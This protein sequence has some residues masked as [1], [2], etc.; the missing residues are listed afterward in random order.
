MTPHAITRL[1]LV[2][3]FGFVAG[4]P[5]T[6]GPACA[7]TRYVTDMLILTVREGPGHEYKVMTTLRSNMAVEVLEEQEKYLKVRTE[8]GLEGWV[9]KQYITTETPKPTIIAGLNDTIGQLRA[10]VEALEQA[11]ASAAGQI[12]A[13]KQNC[14]KRVKD[15][16]KDLKKWQKETAAVKAE[17]N[18]ITRK[19]KNLLAASQ[20]V[21]AVVAERDTL[22]AANTELKAANQNL[23][24]T[25]ERLKQ[26]NDRLVHKEILKWFLAGSAVFFV[27]MIIGKASRKKRPY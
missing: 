21:A 6:G 9:A 2:L 22:R 19:H 25:V 23:K 4:G 11:S 24:S 10:R 1:I 3:L 20:N 12:A 27:G 17:L 18:D 7:E 5:I 26:D 16:E 14:I 13:E 8:N 15:L